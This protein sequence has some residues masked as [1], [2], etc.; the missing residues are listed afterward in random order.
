MNK[1]KWLRIVNAIIFL[2][3]LWMVITAILHDVIHDIFEKIHPLGGLL[4]VIFI[5]IHLILN[6]GW[7][8]AVYLR[9]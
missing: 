7:I 4:L 2:L 3:L 6:W 1:Q 8:K 9:K 5:I